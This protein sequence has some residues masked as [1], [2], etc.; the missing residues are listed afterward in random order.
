LLFF[1]YVWYTPWWDMN[2]RG[3]FHSLPD[4]KASLLCRSLEVFMRFCLLRC[5]LLHYSWWFT[6]PRILCFLTKSVLQKLNQYIVLYERVGRIIFTS[7]WSKNSS[8]QPPIPRSL[9]NTD[10]IYIFLAL[11]QWLK[12]FVFSITT[13]KRYSFKNTNMY[14]HVPHILL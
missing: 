8:L 10:L 13:R 3:F 6:P 7:F 2:H 14:K 11:F 9:V 4:W 5:E 12:F 1:L